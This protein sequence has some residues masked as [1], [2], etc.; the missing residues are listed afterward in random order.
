MLADD[1]K[2]SICS[3]VKD[4]SS[5][6]VYYHRNLI[7]VDSRFETMEGPNSDNV[8][9]ETN[10]SI[11][12]K[13]RIFEPSVIALLEAE[14]VGDPSERVLLIQMLPCSEK[15]IRGIIYLFSLSH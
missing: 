5:Q 1:C 11:K 7:I 9:R 8:R 3:I 10:V 2:K 13:E 6:S 14:L 12:S 4:Y 15:F